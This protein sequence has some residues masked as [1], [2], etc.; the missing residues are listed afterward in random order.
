MK[1]LI[2]ERFSGSKH[3]WS[4]VVVDKPKTKKKLNENIEKYLPEGN[5]T[6]NEFIEHIT[7]LTGIYPLDLVVPEDLL[8]KFERKGLPPISEYLES[9]EDFCW[10][11]PI[12]VNS[13][14][15][16]NKKWYHVVTVI[17]SNSAQLQIRCWNIGKDWKDQ[18]DVNVPYFLK[19]RHDE[20]WG[21]S[22]NGRIDES[23]ARLA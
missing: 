11:I 1:D 13:K 12:A 15:T 16:K 14:K 7:A 8:A 17:D 18:P 10:C 21:F 23:W 4:A 20:N 19:P 6:K 9:D 3:F 5:F 2:D 22:T